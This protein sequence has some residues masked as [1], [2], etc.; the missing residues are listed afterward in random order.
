[1]QEE[2]F[3]RASSLLLAGGL[4]LGLIALAG[5]GS[6]SVSDPPPTGAGSISGT[7][8]DHS[9]GQPVGAAVVLLEQRDAGGI[10]RAVK[11]TTTAPDGSFT[12]GDLPTGKYDVV[13]AASVTSDSGATITYATT[14]TFGVPTTTALDRIPLVPEYGDSM[15]NG[16]PVDI[17]AGATVTTAGAGGVP[18]A[19]EI[20]L[21]A[22]E[23]QITI[24]TF[25]GSTPEITTSPGAA[26]PAGTACANYKL[27]VPESDPVTGTY[28]PAGTSYT[29]PPQSPQEVVYLVEGKAFVAGSAGTPDC[30][31]ST[32]TAGPA[33]PRGTLASH[34]TNLAFTGCQ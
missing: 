3:G 15:P 27:F 32:Q 18:A 17:G 21:S 31:P 22:L 7:V 1:M 11:S 12:A 23:A 33:V 30:A 25:A 2:S 4:A 13:I 8:F 19:A 24:P 14:I 26:C 16:S 9:S 6:A 20:K 34:I 29:I 5:C 28:S 10:D